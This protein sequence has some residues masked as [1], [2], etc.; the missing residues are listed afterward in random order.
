MSTVIST[1][2]A[3]E[4]LIVALDVPDIAAAEALVNDLDG[5]ATF[6]KV[7]LTLQLATGVESFIRTLIQAKKRVFLT[8]SITT[9]QRRSRKQWAE[10]RDWACLS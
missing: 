9:L 7:G 6:F 4:R 5:A 2:D 8:T 1:V 3:R 10:P